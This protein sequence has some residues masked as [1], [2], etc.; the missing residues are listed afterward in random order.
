MP[1][2]VA[3]EFQA[4]PG[5]VKQ[6]MDSLLLVLAC[7]LIAIGIVTVF[8]AS[9]AP[10]LHAQLS[11]YHLLGRQAKWAACGL[12]GMIVALCVPYWFWRRF[13][14]HAVWL[15]II[16]LGLCF[17]PHVSHSIHGASR[18]IGPSALQIQPSE[19]AKL[20]LIVFL[21]S[22]CA[23][24]AKRL[25]NFKKG[26]LPRLGVIVVV[27]ALIAHEPDLG[28]A[29]VLTSTS[30]AMLFLAGARKR[31]IGAV[32]AVA[33][34]V[35]VAYSVTKTYRMHRLIAFM[36]PEKYQQGDGYQVWHSLL[37][38]GSAGVPGLGFGEGIEK[39]NI[40]MAQTDFIFAVL[41]EEWGLI[42][43]LTVLALFLL[44]AM[45][46]Y[47]IA[48]A[49]KDPFGALLAGGLTCLISFQTLI[50]VA[51][52]TSSI[53]NTGVPLPFVSYG[54]SAL[55]LMMV[56]VGLLLNISRFPEGPGLRKKEEAEIPPNERDFNRRWDRRQY[57]PRVE[58]DDTPR[59]RRS[60]SAESRPLTRTR[61]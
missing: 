17:V 16:L 37:A 45:R 33:L 26:L 22:V 35:V 5:P 32:V 38:L 28:T 25:R 24:A 20:A 52:V 61:E 23:G 36:N 40:P 27:S 30:L 13:A 49:T 53:P 29:I 41:G 4:T 59:L 55:M 3:E 11:P 1:D 58:T 46:G 42:G 50:N 7:T 8:D 47:S 6:P 21:A 54:G 9:Y 39:L 48:H 14:T 10:A 43:T 57:V 15:S 44:V 34:L 60:A 56:S 31:H 2:V 51:V 19:F 18:W 12:V